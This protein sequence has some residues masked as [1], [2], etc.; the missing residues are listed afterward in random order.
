M[1]LLGF[2]MVF[3]WFSYGSARH[4]VFAAVSPAGR[5]ARP[6]RGAAEP[7]GRHGGAQR[8]R[9]GGQD[10]AAGG[11]QQGVEVINMLP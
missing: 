7:P 3:P 10:G 5:P 11:V 8:A 6:R 1:V 4:H 2:P 9:R